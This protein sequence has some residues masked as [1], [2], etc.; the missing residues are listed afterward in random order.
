MSYVGIQTVG[1]M[2]DFNRLKDNFINMHYRYVQI[3]K[4]PTRGQAVLDKIWTNMYVTS[5][6]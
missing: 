1:L 3:V 6:R 2:G 5:V 4:D